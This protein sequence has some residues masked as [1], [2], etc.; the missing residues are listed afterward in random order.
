MIRMTKASN[1]GISR[2]KSLQYARLGGRKV[3]AYSG[4]RR[5]L[6][7]LPK[8]FSDKLQVGYGDE[9][10]CRMDGR[11]LIVEKFEFLDH[12]FG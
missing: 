4:D 11:K 8:V 7:E 2:I 3:Q 12:R 6:I 5:L 10:K 9:L 1:K